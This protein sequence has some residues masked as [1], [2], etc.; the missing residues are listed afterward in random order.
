MQSDP[1]DT[2]PH[3]DNTEDSFSDVFLTKAMDR[4]LRLAEIT[5]STPT[6]PAILITVVPYKGSSLLGNYLYIYIYVYIY[7]YI[8]LYIHLY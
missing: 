6:P 1:L 3:S 7:I 8:Y 2:A 5:L 4:L